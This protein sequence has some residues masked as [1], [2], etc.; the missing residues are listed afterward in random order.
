MR[1]ALSLS[2]FSTDQF[3]TIVIFPVNYSDSITGRGEYNVSR[4]Y[5]QLSLKSRINDLDNYKHKH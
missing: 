3:V 4:I 5:L 2:V 1:S